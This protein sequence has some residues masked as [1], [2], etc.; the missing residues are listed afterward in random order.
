L[1]T[2]KLKSNYKQVEL[3]RKFLKIKIPSEWTISKLNDFATVHGRI[4]WKNLRADEYTKTGY[5]MLSVWSLVESA[6]YGID[7][8][9]GV[10]RLNQFRYDESPEIKLKENDVLIAKDGDVGRIGYVKKLPEPTT[11]N[12][13]AVVVRVKKNTV[14]P[15]YLYWFM[16]F[17]PFQ[18]YCI[19]FT[20]GTTVPLLTQKDLKNS[21]FP[22]PTQYEQ[23]KIASILSNVD[24]LIQKFNLLIKS[25]KKL[26]TGLM[27]KLLTKGI[28]HTKFKKVKSLFGKYEEIPEDWIVNTINDIGKIVTGSTPSTKISDY[29]GTE[30]LWA[31]PTD[32]SDD[33]NIEKTEN[34]LSAKGFA[35]SRKIPARSVLFVCIGSTIGKIGMSVKKMATNQQINSV[36]CKNNNPDFLY[37]QL[38]ANS[39]KIK[40]MANQVAVPILNKT[41]FGTIKIQIPTD[42]DEQEKISIILSNVDSKILDY[43]SKKSSL[44]ILKKGLMQK[45][46]TGELRVRV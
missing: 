38:S 45:L 22:I 4:G 37:Y 25:T 1:Q 33:K 18:S 7:Y 5:L 2:Q 42:I 30:F 36:I 46:L 24:N 34:M 39:I 32:L 31:S 41:D 19:A 3:G 6:P 20:S 40:N 23:Q 10:K 26:K 12:S 9:K 17:K 28:G 11:V 8:S 27:Q 21:L 15:E 35:I 14:N 16:K 43:Q 29:Y 13:H 44:E